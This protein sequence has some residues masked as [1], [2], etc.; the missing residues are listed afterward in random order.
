MNKYPNKAIR[1]IVPFPEGGPSDIIARLLATRLTKRVGQPVNIENRAGLNG[2]A[3]TTA[4]GK[5]HPDG[6]TVIMATSSHTINPNVYGNLPF[7]WQNDF[8]PVSLVASVANVLVLHPSLPTKSVDQFIAY[9]KASPQP[10]SFSSSG[11]YGP[12]HLAGELFKRMAGVD[13]LHVPYRTHAAAG[14]ALASGKVQVMF[15]A[16]GPAMPEVRA[17]HL[18][19]L[20]VT[21]LDRIPT[22]QDL[23][24]LHECGLSGYEINPA[25]GIL[26]PAGTSRAIVDSLSAAIADVMRAADVKSQLENDGMKAVGSTPEQYALHLKS[27]FEKW[28][29]IIRDCGIKTQEVPAVLAE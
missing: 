10:L 27:A 1:V 8:T 22:A 29:A 24:T 14:A 11:D 21:T 25:M 13:M 20:A 2:V 12:P 17:G 9:A 6:H 15:D 18:R 28:G 19:A 23:P 4:A 5:A 3:G 16:V 7:D 26:T